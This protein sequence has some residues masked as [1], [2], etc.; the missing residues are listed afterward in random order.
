MGLDAR[1]ITSVMELIIYLPLLPLS[2]YLILKH[3]FK[4]EGWLYLLLLSIGKS[5]FIT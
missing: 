1:G 2:G 5:A 3:G 4:R